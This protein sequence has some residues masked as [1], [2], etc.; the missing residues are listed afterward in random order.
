MHNTLVAKGPDFQRGMVNNLP[1]GN[2]DVAPTIL[3]ILGVKPPMPMDGRVLHEALKESRQASV[4]PPETKTIEAKHDLGVLEWRQ[5]LKYTTY[6]HAIYF[7]EGN[8]APRIK[9]R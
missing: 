2:I 9:D 5:Y 8:G 4:S 1:S 3:H 6:D 7:D